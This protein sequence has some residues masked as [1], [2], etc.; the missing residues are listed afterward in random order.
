MNQLTKYLL[1]SLKKQKIPVV[2]LNQLGKKSLSEYMQDL[3][4]KPAY[5]PVYR[6]SLPRKKKIAPISRDVATAKQYQAIK[7]ALKNW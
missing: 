6:Y 3:L 5:A 1:A 2:P 7:K 4:K